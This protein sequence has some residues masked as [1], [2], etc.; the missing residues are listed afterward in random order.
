V[1][2]PETCADDQCCLGS[3][4]VAGGTWGQCGGDG[5]PCDACAVGET[6]PAATRTCTACAAQTGFT[7][8]DGRFGPGGTDPAAACSAG[9]QFACACAELADGSGSVCWGSGL[10]CLGSGACEDDGDCVSFGAG[11]RCV[12]RGTCSLFDLCV[13]LPT[14]CVAPCRAT[15]AARVAAADLPPGAEM[16]TAD[17]LRR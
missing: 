15:A 8:C 13:G 9:G 2:D 4:C 3:D 17:G 14:V 5:V 12:K 7:A 6:C 11:W 1:C 16:V 10:G